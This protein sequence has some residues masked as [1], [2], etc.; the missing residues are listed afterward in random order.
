M[1]TLID[2]QREKRTALAVKQREHLRKRLAM[3][4]PAD[5]PRRARKLAGED[6]RYKP[7]P[8]TAAQRREER[9]EAWRGRSLHVGPSLS[10][11][12]A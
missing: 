2:I 4:Y 12:T 3:S 1:K 7:A 5:D 10:R 6:L 8:Q 11:R 9:A